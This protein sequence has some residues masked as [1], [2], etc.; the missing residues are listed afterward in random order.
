MSALRVLVADDHE[1][2][3]RGVCALINA[4]SGWIVCGEASTGQEV[5]TRARA[6]QPD[7]VVLDLSMPELNGL[8]A[9]RQIHH[10][11]P[12]CEVLIL[13]MY[14]SETMIRDL[15]RAGV[16]G[17]ILKSDA[18]HALVAAVDAVSHH[19]PFFTPGLAFGGTEPP[20]DWIGRANTQ[21]LGER[22]L[23]RREREVLQL[24]VEG[25]TARVVAR[26]LGIS[27]KT[28]DTHRTHIKEKLGARSVVDLVRYAVRNR[29]IEP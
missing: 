2:V 15:L 3:R 12:H 14:D 19:K 6:L 28:V 24:L 1:V 11:V 5:I 23:T 29:L 7:V 10:H 18:A 27:I 4:Q 16:R 9:A 26:L 8:E 25:R 13:T 20:F 17:C 22:E 21:E